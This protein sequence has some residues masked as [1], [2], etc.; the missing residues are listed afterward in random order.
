M[1]LN[2]KTANRAYFGL[3]ARLLQICFRELTIRTAFCM[4]VLP[5]SKDVA[6]MF[7][8]IFGRS[9]FYVVFIDTRGF[10]KPLRYSYTESRHNPIHREFC[11]NG[12]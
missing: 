2:A 9:K 10:H 8:V 4:E 7:K 1:R 5:T 12:E 3:P 11:H 6:M